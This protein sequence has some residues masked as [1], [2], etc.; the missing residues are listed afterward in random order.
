[1]LKV[2]LTK[3]EVDSIIEEISASPVVC[4]DFETT[5]VIPYEC[6]VELGAVAWYDKEGNLKKNSWTFTEERNY[7]KNL[8]TW[9]WFQKNILSSFWWR[10][11]VKIV[12]H[13]IKF[14]IVIAL[15]RLA[16]YPVLPGQL[17][18]FLPKGE[19]I[20]T[21]ILAWL[22]DENMPKSLKEQSKYRLNK[23][24][25]TY[26][27]IDTERKNLEKE[28]KNKI[29]EAISLSWDRYYKDN[30]KNS[31][32]VH[33]KEE[34]TPK[35]YRITDEA[36]S[37]LN[38][39]SFVE[40]MEERV[41][42][43]ITKFYQDK[44]IKLFSGYAEEDVTDPIELFEKDYYPGLNS[45]GLW[46]WYKE[47]ELPFMLA[48]MESEVCGVKL[49]VDKLSLME[50]E[51]DWFISL[52]TQ[53]IVEEAKK[54]GFDDS[55]NP[56]SHNQL[57][58]LL[59]NKMRLKPPKWAKA[60]KSG[61]FPTNAEVLEELADDNPI[62]RWIIELGSAN[63]L[64]STFIKKPLKRALKS[65]GNRI[66]CVYNTVGCITGRIASS[67]PNLM[68]QTKAH[69][70][71]KAPISWFMKRY[72]EEGYIY[73]SAEDLLSDFPEGIPGWVI[74]EG[75]GD[76]NV[77]DTVFQMIPLRE[78]FIVEEDEVMI[79]ADFSQ[80]ELRLIAHVSKDPG[81]I[82]AYTIWRCAQCKKYGS[83]TS[84][85]KFCPECGAK[86]GKMDKTKPDQPVLEG[87]VLGL[88]LHTGIASDMGL[89][90]K[91]PAGEARD[92]G[93]E[94]N[95]GLN[96]L[97]AESTLQQKLG[98]SDAEAK[99]YY[100]GYFKKRPGVDIFHKEVKRDLRKHGFFRMVHGRK[101]RFFAQQR[102]IN[103]RNMSDKDIGKTERE[104]V[105]RIIQG[106][107]ADVQKKCMT[108]FVEMKNADP[109]LKDCQ[110]LLQIHDEMVVSCKKG[111]EDKVS[112]L[113]LEAMEGTVTNLRVPIV[114]E[115][116]ICKNWQ[117]GK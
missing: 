38:K 52:K 101:T 98:C 34:N 30:K 23:P 78:V 24:R 62:C 7:G 54:Y 86:T 5:G 60:T 77:E 42:P 4:L 57:K 69:K 26:K 85:L 1:M 112:A 76:E 8:V 37:M 94:F 103:S 59:W 33:G 68:N 25:K 20:D 116:S 51:V 9:K 53:Q 36:P 107:A 70:M 19:I 83:T 104:A 21:M 73:K 55:F 40:Y 31:N 43:S 11:D 84:P 61:A 17:Q 50:K 93:K 13:N 88:D 45:E 91:M 27:V 65:F 56:G 75:S 111:K 3:K 67:E 14:D 6:G 106:S 108:R 90:E 18:D 105:N 109:Y 82:K 71:P 63:T 2:E 44:E 64:A 46:D 79:V 92:K 47:V 74:V 102:L 39:K 87:F 66:R 48:T 89:L 115:M 80:I 22:L 12:G 15:R 95:F 117:E 49:D 100:N 28:R 113:L 35:L 10:E 32:G 114:A 96:Y 99:E 97:M 81:M 16:P 29:K 72:A 110:V 58:D 41:E